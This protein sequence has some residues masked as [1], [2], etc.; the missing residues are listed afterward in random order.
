VVWHPFIV[1]AA[2]MQFDPLSRF[3]LSPPWNQARHSPNSSVLLLAS[4]DSGASSSDPS[5]PAVWSPSSSPGE[6]VDPSAVGLISP[7]SSAA[8]S[9]FDLASY[10]ADFFNGEASTSELVRGEWMDTKSD[11]A[12]FRHLFNT[13]SSYPAG[14]DAALVGRR[15]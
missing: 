7:R 8:C 14:G 2:T 1:E 3:A 5:I 6:N 13:A 10:D 12:S 15:L 9:L 4:Q 11:P